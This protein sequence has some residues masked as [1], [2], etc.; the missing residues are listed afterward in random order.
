MNETQ[1][2]QIV[3]DPKLEALKSRIEASGKLDQVTIDSNNITKLFQ[4]LLNTPSIVVTNQYFDFP[5]RSTMQLT[6]T[7]GIFNQSL[8]IT[9]VFTL[10]NGDFQLLLNSYD[11]DL[12]LTL[13]QLAK[14]GLLPSRIEP[15]SWPSVAINN[16]SFIF[17]SSVEALNLSSG[18]GPIWDFLG[19]TGLFVKSPKL[20]IVRTYEAGLVNN[21]AFTTGTFTN[22]NGTVDIPIKVELPIGLTRWRVSLTEPRS[23]SQ[24]VGI[25]DALLQTN[26]IDLLPEEFTEK[27]EAIDIISFSVALNTTNRS[28]STVQLIVRSTSDWVIINNKLKL[29]QGITLVLTGSRFSN[30]SPLQY[31]GGISGTACVNYDSDDTLVEARASIPIPISGRNWTIELGNNDQDLGLGRLMAIVPGAEAILPKGLMNHLDQI[32]LEFLKLSFHFNNGFSFTHVTF[33]IHSEKSWQLPMLQS[34]V[35]LD[36]LKF[37]LDVDFPYSATTTS[38]ALSGDIVIANGEVTIPVS[39]AKEKLD[40]NWQLN[41]TSESIPLPSISHFSDFMGNDVLVTGSPSGLLGLGNFAIEDLNLKWLLGSGSRLEL[42]SFTVQSTGETPAWNLVPGYFILTDLTISLKIENVSV[43][44]KDI[45]GSI[46]TT[47]TLPISGQE[48]DLELEMIARKPGSDKPWN[49]AGSLKEEHELKNLLKGLKLPLEVVTILPDLTVTQFDLAMEPTSKSFSTSMT[50]KAAQPWTIISVGD[51]EVTLNELFFS[52]ERYADNTDLQV[53]GTFNIGTDNECPISVEANYKRGIW[54]FIGTFNNSNNLTINE[55]LEKYIHGLDTRSI[56]QVEITSINVA[57]EK[58][59]LS[60][61]AGDYSTL[62]FFI[63]GE[64]TI[65]SIDTMKIKAAVNVLYDSRKAERR[66]YDGTRVKG[67]LKFGGLSFS[68]MANYQNNK[69]ST[70]TFQLVYKNITVKTAID[71]S[72]PDVV[73]FDFKLSATN[74]NKGLSLGDVISTLIGAAT[75]EAPDIPSPWD[76]INKI[77]LNEF[78][79]VFTYN[80]ENQSKTVGLTYAPNINLGFITIDELSLIYAPDGDKDQGPVQFL[81]TKGTFLGLPIDSETDQEKIGWD[82]RDPTKAPKVPG[83]GDAAFKLENLS[84][85]NQV[86]IKNGTPPNSVVEAITNMENAFK[87]DNGGDNL[88]TALYFDKNYGW[89]IGAKF[90]LVKDFN[91]AVIFYDPVIYGLAI[92][93]KGGKFNG[94]CFQVLYKKITDHVGVFQIDLTLPDFVRKQQFGAVSI[95]LPSLS[96]S[97]FTN[98]DFLIDMGFPHHGDFARSFGLEFA[99]FTGEGGFYF[100]KLSNDTA[101]DFNLPEADGQFNPVIAFGIGIKA[102]FEEA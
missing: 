91:I 5:D 98:G 97:I 88:P 6:A 96:L 59:P 89:L 99:I 11:A 21:T 57:L 53:K 63:N 48:K 4:P 7:A 18:V 81:V 25:M 82:L 32:T 35:E 14:A 19:Y 71:V 22:D 44:Q 75:G 3:V 51:T 77:P 85:G 20:T 100:G 87:P 43:S 36:E 69:F 90:T 41:V 31:S 102:G 12:S 34:N 1:E 29:D 15:D 39:I 13:R 54:N 79:L 64:L 76:F 30:G 38:G 70:Y 95:T 24:G 94:L 40:E 50:I 42:L 73:K 65:P 49:F 45:S 83:M 28:I 72:N 84:L 58:G 78:G 92:D 80:K 33:S 60:I 17:D 93:V 26:I 2:I 86:A 27:L 67:V 55:V 23:L 62:D 74:L 8:K 61:R 47:V 52:L 37:A 66:Q 16:I 9:A 101:S 10:E 68:A 46:I 56:P